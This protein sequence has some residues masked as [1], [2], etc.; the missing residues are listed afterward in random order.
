MSSDL[1]IF[2]WSGMGGEGRG[3]RLEGRTGGGGGEGG[4]VEL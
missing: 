2:F 4:G 3:G 1:C